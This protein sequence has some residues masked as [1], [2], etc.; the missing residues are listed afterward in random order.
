M[1]RLPT[2]KRAIISMAVLG[3]GS[4]ACKGGQSKDESPPPRQRVD[5]VE[6]AAKPTV[7]LAGFCDE[8]PSVDEAKSFAMPPLDGGSAPA[9]AGWRWIN[10]WATWCKPC[11]EELPL[12]AGWQEK[13]ERDRVSLDV[14]FLSVDDA[15]SDI[16]VFRKEHPAAPESLR[17]DSRD[18]LGPWLETLGLGESTALPIQLFIDDAGKLRCTRLGPVSE[19]DYDTIVALV[20]EG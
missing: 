5:A 6:A 8:R 20:R 17:L 15:A 4:S 19:R 9:A 18:N 12:L 2:V 1:D 7:D 13:L 14:V 16:D 3:L 10:V 11:V